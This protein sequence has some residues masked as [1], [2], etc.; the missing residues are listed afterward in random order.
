MFIPLS[1]LSLTRNQFIFIWYCWESCQVD[2]LWSLVLET[3][4]SF[5]STTVLKSVHPP[6]HPPIHLPSLCPSVH[7]SIH[8]FMYPSIL[9]SVYP[10]AHLS[11]HPSF[12]QTSSICTSTPLS[13]PLSISSSLYPFIHA[14]VYSSFF[15][16]DPFSSDRCPKGMWDS[17]IAAFCGKS[18]CPAGPP[19]G[20][21]VSYW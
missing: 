10:S 4:A 12:H 1:A 11:L 3:L 16:G 7:C 19:I 9:P 13:L 8:L 18:L 15:S 2:G 21:Q 14:N 20:A 5:F 6:I 17:G